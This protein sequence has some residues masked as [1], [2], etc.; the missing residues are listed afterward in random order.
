MTEDQDYYLCI[1]AYGYLES[2]FTI[3]YTSDEDIIK[4]LRLD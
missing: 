1:L 2:K 3:E 4:L